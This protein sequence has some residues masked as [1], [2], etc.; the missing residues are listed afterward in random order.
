MLQVAKL[1]NITFKN[2][3]LFYISV[4]ISL[5]VFS[6]IACSQQ[7]ADTSPQKF[8]DEFRQAVLSNDTN[9]ITNMTQFPFEQRGVDDSQPA[10]KY[11]K[12]QFDSLFKKVLEQPVVTMEGDNIIMHTTRKIIIATE[13]I[14]DEHKLTAGSFRVDQLVFELK[15]NKWKLVRAYLEE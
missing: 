14:Q 12:D 11:S 13:T 15:N 6:S 1:M 9:A 2:F 4:I 3:K 7:N 10:V 8:W 5:A